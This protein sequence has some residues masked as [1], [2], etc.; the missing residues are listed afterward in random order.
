MIK[1]LILKTKIN[2]SQARYQEPYAVTSLLHMQLVCPVSSKEQLKPSLILP[3][4][5]E[6]KNGLEN[7]HSGLFY[8]K[9]KSLSVTI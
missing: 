7:L 2:V 8:L 1:I 9:R 6:K 3:Q 5:Q 4:V